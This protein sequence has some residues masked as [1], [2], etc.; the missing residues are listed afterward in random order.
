MKIYLNNPDNYVLFAVMDVDFT[1]YNS[2]MNNLSSLKLKVVNETTT[3][4]F[5]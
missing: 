3:H 2:Y 4:F 1:F 5:L